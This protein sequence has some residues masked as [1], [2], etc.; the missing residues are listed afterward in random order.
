MSKIELPN[1]AN[2]SNVS[3]MN[4]NFKK[5]EDALNEE[6]LYRKGYL[7]EPNE[8]QTDLDM[9]GNSILNVV[10]GTGPNDL[11]TRSY[12]EQQLTDINLEFD[13][14]CDEV[15]GTLSVP[16]ISGGEMSLTALNTVSISSSDITNSDISGGT[17]TNTQVSGG[18]VSNSTIVS[19]IETV[20]ASSASGVI[21]CSTGLIF[22]R[23]LTAPTNI[24]FTN[25]TSGKSATL[26]LRSNGN[27]VTW[28]V[29]I[30]WVGGFAPEL[31]TSDVLTFWQVGAQLFGSYVGRI[32]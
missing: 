24:S 4:D 29:G 25:I 21:D 20:T 31:T 19:V 22:Q 7:G 32:V 10:T 26:H 6:V 13:S 2:P 17:V 5:I 1:I 14:K 18:S 11:A 15:N 27:A 3:L 28:P 16:S 12:V 9:N 8:I 23:N 30:K